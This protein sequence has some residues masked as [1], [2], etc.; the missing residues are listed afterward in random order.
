MTPRVDASIISWTGQHDNAAAIQR[1][2][3]GAVDRVTVVY[4]DADDRVAPGDEHWIRVPNDWF[5]G[6]KF[7]LTLDRF[8]G[9]ILF[10]VN[11]DARYPDW[12]AL[13]RRCRD[14]FKRLPRLGLWAPNVD[15]TPWTLERISIA[16]LDDSSMHFVALTDSIVWAI[17]S[18]VAGRLRRF[19]YDGNNLGWGIDQ[20]ASLHSHATN[21]L[22]AVDSAATVLH[23]KSKGYD[24][25][26]AVEESKGF[27]QQLTLPEKIHWFLVNRFVTTEPP[28]ESSF[29]LL[30]SWGP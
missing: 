27:M 22:V 15:H 20:A 12:G 21:R 19:D 13:A 2:L 16:T 23:P 10:Q 5:F 26:A 9:D 18:D 11:A 8:D 14:A 1:Q 24:R 6:R 29:T 28:T 4:S 30:P 25:T 7:K 17:S 3:A